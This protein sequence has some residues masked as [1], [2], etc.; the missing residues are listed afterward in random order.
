MLFVNDHN[1]I[2]HEKCQL[3]ASRSFILIRDTQDNHV[4]IHALIR[5]PDA[6]FIE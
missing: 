6:N 1:G 5:T 4:N 2:D 3:K